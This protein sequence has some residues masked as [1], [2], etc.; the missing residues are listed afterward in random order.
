[1]GDIQKAC[2]SK[3]CAWVPSKNAI[4]VEPKNDCGFRSAKTTSTSNLVSIF[5]YI[6]LVRPD[7]G[8]KMFLGRFIGQKK[9]AGRKK[10]IYVYGRLLKNSTK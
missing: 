1:M 10:N 3:P 8:W 5:S 6:L 2:T 7:Q 9:S 4:T